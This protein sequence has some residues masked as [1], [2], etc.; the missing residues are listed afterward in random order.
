MKSPLIVECRCNHCPAVLRFEP[1]Q[2]GSTITCPNCQMETCLTDPKQSRGKKNKPS[3]TWLLVVVG[4]LAVL[5]L[6]KVI[7][8]SPERD[9]EAAKAKQSE[10]AWYAA[11]LFVTRFLKSPSTAKF[12]NP[13]TD[14]TVGTI[15]DFPNFEVVGYVDSQNSFGAMLRS[16]WKA[17]IEFKDG[18]W[19]M[20]QMEIN[21]Q[22]VFP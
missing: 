21:G 8:P 9:A 4:I 10:R 17:N 7:G 22:K 13:N 19:K 14:S 15:R 18:D 12:P 20:I 6:E 11:Q 2:I 5:I 3:I 1:N 16:H